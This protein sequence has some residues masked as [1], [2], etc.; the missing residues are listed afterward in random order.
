MHE[1]LNKKVKVFVDRPLASKDPK[2]EIYYPLNYG[3]IPNTISGDG[4]EVDA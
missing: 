4:E 2:H 1:Y 3:Y